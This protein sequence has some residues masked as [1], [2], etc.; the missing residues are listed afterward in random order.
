MLAG[1]GLPRIRAGHTESYRVISSH[2]TLHGVGLPPVQGGHTESCRN[3]LSYIAYRIPWLW[4]VSS[5]TGSA[6]A[7]KSFGLTC[8]PLQFRSNNCPMTGQ[9][10][11]YSTSKLWGSHFARCHVKLRACASV[12]SGAAQAP[13]LIRLIKGRQTSGGAPLRGAPSFN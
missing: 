13:P 1:I 10:L 6:G 7:Q 2:I 12:H 8:E 11:A 4:L 5:I 3:L 9:P